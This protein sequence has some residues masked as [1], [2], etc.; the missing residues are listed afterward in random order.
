[1]YCVYVTENRRPRLDPRQGQRNFP[2]VSA[3]SLPLG[4]TQPPVEARPGRDA[5]HSPASSAE[6]RKE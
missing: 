6:V 3:S 1:V 2:L 4:P 5:D